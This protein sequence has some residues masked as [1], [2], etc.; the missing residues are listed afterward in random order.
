MIGGIAAGVQSWIG[1]V[2]AGG[3]FAGAQAAAMGGG[4]PAV[5]QAVGGAVGGVVGGVVTRFFS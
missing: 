1:N 2:A 5:F 3:F 4:V